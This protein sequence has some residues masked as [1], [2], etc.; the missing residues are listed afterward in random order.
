MQCSFR[1]FHCSTMFGFQGYV[2]ISLTSGGL[3]PWSVAKSEGELKRMKA[4][5]DVAK[6]CA[7]RGLP[8]VGE[9]VLRCRRAGRTVRPD[10][11]ALAQLLTS[12]HSRKVDNTLQ[13]IEFVLLVLVINKFF[14][15]RAIAV[16][17]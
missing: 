14:S 5:C 4:D 16:H 1:C 2:L 9:L 11:D 6:L 13:L 12:M 17:G 8:E 15:L 7:E 3:L 10:Y